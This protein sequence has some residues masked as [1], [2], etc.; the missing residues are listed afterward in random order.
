M[1]PPAIRPIAFKVDVEFLEGIIKALTHLEIN[2]ERLPKFNVPGP[3]ITNKD[4]RRYGTGLG[5]EVGAGRPDLPKGTD[6][7]E[8]SPDPAVLTAL[9]FTVINTPTG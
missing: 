5:W 8:A 3:R 9:T 2:A 6:A 4:P 1:I 7:G